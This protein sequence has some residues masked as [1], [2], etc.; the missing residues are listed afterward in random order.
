MAYVL[1]AE[2]QKLLVFCSEDIPHVPTDTDLSIMYPG[3]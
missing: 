1:T 2:C 3:N